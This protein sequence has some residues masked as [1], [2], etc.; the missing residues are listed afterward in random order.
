MGRPVKDTVDFFPHYATS[1]KT[2]FILESKFGNDGY[3]FWFKLLELLCQQDGHYYDYSTP[4]AWE[5]LIA[6]SRVTGVSG[7]EILKT[8]AD[9]GAIDSDLY[10][11]QVIWV[12]KLVDN[13]AFVYEK[14]KRPIPSKPSFCDRKPSFCP[15]KSGTDDFLIPETPQR[16]GTEINGT[17]RKGGS[18]PYSPP[19]EG[20]TTATTLYVKYFG[21][22]K[23]ITEGL[24]QELQTLED[25]YGLDWLKQAFAETVLQDEK[26]HTLAYVRRILERWRQD[27]QKEFIDAR[28]DYKTCR[29]L[30][31]RGPEAVA[32]WL[33]EHNYLP[34]GAGPEGA[35]EATGPP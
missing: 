9:L 20:D 2:L 6:R 17:E 12:Q 5:F 4:A 18:T 34:A 11:Q 32:E 3:A 31:A 14:R 22:K 28:L 8:L 7:T 16:N 27:D 1:G 23:T 30:Y 24:K 26:K 10:H 35:P 29:D 13:F 19:T 21:K 15:E 33:K 25:T